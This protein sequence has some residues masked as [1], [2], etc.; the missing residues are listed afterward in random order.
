MKEPLV[1]IVIPT[2][3][4]AEFL[5]ECLISISKQ[6]YKNIEVIIIDGQSKDG[7][8]ELAQKHKCNI[9][10]F[11]PNVLKGT[12]DAPHRRNYGAK[13]AKGEFVYY[14]DA[15]MELTPNVL[16]DAV[17]LCESGYQAIIIPEDS[18]GVGIWAQAKNL[19]RRCYY[20]DN[21][22]EAPRF[23]RKTIW[24]ELG[25]LDES[26]G[27]GGD[28][29][30]LHQKLLD[31]QY[32]VGRTKSLVMHNEGNLTLKKLIKKRFMYGLDS[33]KY[34]KKRPNEGIKSYFPI[35]KAYI[36]N[37]KLFLSRPIDTIAFIIM[38]TVEY[39]AGFSGILYAFYR[40][41]VRK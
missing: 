32:T 22:I 1:S 6:A 25:G 2:K 7:T 27:G 13:K 38:R 12:F 30:D 34:I 31:K 29:W 18:F 11:N 36:A 41:W 19:E 3:N 21:S 40:H 28:D 24:M 16:L 17:H 5:D 37:W 9:Y 33:A 14:V 15:D 35:R 20:G 23:L 8:I 26:L 39:L 10:Q 4:S